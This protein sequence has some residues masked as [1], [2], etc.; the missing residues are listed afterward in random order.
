MY[1]DL[2]MNTVLFADDQAVG[3]SDELRL[4]LQILKIVRSTIL[5]F[6]LLKK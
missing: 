1:L 4:V 5:K 6:L 2:V 3:K